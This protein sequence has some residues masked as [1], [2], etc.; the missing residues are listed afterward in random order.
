MFRKGIGIQRVDP[1]S[2]SGAQRFPGHG[3]LGMALPGEAGKGQPTGFHVFQD[4]AGEVDS[5][6]LESPE[7]SNLVDALK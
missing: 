6:K 7:E 3:P 5:S 4:G 1:P 2:G